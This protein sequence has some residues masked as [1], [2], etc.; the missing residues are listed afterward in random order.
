MLE[1]LK[2]SFPMDRIAPE[3][4]PGFLLRWGGAVMIAALEFQGICTLLSVWE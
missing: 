2:S 4:G 1:T 3:F